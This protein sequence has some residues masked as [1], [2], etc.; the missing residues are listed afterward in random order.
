MNHQH[1]SHTVVSLRDP[2]RSGLQKLP[3]EELSV[4][5]FAQRMEV[6]A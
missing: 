3:N 5:E 2:D 4:G 1:Q 6:N